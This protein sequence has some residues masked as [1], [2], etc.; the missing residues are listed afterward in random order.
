MYFTGNSYDAAAESGYNLWNGK[1]VIH[2][3]IAF[4]ERNIQFIVWKRED[5][6]KPTQT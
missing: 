1:K 4:V 5:N 3:S 2:E 6:C